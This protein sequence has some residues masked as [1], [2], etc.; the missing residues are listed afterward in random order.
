MR[1]YISGPLQAAGDLPTARRFYVAIADMLTELGHYVYVPHLRTDPEAAAGLSAEQVY[2]QDLQA[3]LDCDV[4]VAH[5]GAPST[6]VGAEVAIA[7]HHGRGVIGIRRSGEG[8][9][10][11]AE[12]LILAECG[13]IFT[14]HDLTDLREQ[15]VVLF[16][17]D[18]GK[19]STQARDLRSGRLIAMGA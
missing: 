5:V 15:L 17:D 3:M 18:Q 1:F 8:I 16:A 13:K 12:G 6:G 19:W 4:V 2:K 11:F 9:S 14:F 10:R 7:L